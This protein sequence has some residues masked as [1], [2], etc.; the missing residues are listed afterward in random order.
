M[1]KLMIYSIYDSKVQ[2]YDRPLVMRNRGEAI[3]GWEQAANDEKTS[4]SAHPHDYALMEIGEF[5]DQT[6]AI[7]PLT[8]PVSLGLAVNFKRAPAP[9]PTLFNQQTEGNN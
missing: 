4:I 8:V 1:A 3:R 2:F 9:T 6:G 5:D 7:T